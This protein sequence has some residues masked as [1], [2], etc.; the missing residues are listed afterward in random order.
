VS[1]ERTNKKTLKTAKAIELPRYIREWHELVEKEPKRFC[2][3]IKQL[4]VMIEGLLARD[5]IWYDDTDV[6]A[7]I[8]F[9]R[10]FRHQTGR[11]AGEPLEL[12]IEQRYIVACVFGLKTYDEEL[13]LEV[14]YFIELVLLVA[15]KWGK[16]LFISALAAW[17]LLADGEPSAQVW[18]LATQKS[19]AAIV[20]DNTKALLRSSEVMT[21]P[22]NPWT[23][24]RTRR[25]RD[26]TEMILFPATNSY[27]KPA[28]K[29]SQNQDGLNPHCFV[30]DEC[31]AVRDRN[32]YDVFSSATGARTQPLGIIISTFGFVRE[33]IFDSILKR[34]E[35][36][37]TGQTDERLF[38]MIFRIDKT[39]DPADRSCWIKANPGLPEA[40]PT[41][42]YL[43]GEYQKALAD[44]AQ[45]PSFLAKHLNRAASSSVVYFNLHEVDQCATDMLVDM[46]MNTYAV[47]GIDAS[48]T[49]DLTCA[50]ALIPKNGRFYIFQRYF[51]AE[52]RIE[53][54]SKQDQMAYESFTRTNATDPIHQELLKISLGSMVSTEDIAEWY[55]WLAEEFGVTFWKIGADRWHYNEVSKNLAEKGFM[56]EDREGIGV[57]FSIPWGS[58][59]LS[60]PMKQTR[61]LFRDRVFVYSRHNGLLRWCVTNVAAKVDANNN[62][63]PDR[64]ASKARI[65]G[66]ASLLAAYVAYLKVKDDFAVYQK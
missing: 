19:Q 66:Y 24:W 16:S 4:K 54:N 45:M 63:M 60:E 17:M 2:E 15:R 1:N 28:G 52:Q 5:D 34:C 29:N 50:T 53:Q 33:S 36:R 35:D 31:H 32:T 9:A 56:R 21:P 48:E 3:D 25:D 38:P 47:G 6:E 58:Y 61:V 27:M 59:T 7:F 10:L 42:R 55:A 30:I 49:T 13:D 46:I 57:T 22:D 23:Y 44:P 18:C 14:R 41:M 62:V 65:D 64:R 37:L 26:N 51:I 8:E 43:E 40:R 11:W 12:S 39:D 20:Y